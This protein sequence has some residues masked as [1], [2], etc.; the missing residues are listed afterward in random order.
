MEMPF[1]EKE[2]DMFIET[3]ENSANKCIFDTDIR[4]ISTKKYAICLCPLY[5]ITNKRP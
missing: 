3:I 2:Y 5:Y 1:I 4:W